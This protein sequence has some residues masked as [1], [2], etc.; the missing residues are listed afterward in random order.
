MLQI[1][2]F[3]CFQIEHNSVRDIPNTY[4]HLL[5]GIYKYLSII[6]RNV[7]QAGCK[8]II[9]KFC[10]QAYITIPLNLSHILEPAKNLFNG[11]RWSPHFQVHQ[12]TEYLPY[13]QQLFHRKFSCAT[14]K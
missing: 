1:Y 11:T 7:S 3:I 5:Q 9:Q 13:I 4:T 12:T 8:T 10:R 14:K 2:C 6:I